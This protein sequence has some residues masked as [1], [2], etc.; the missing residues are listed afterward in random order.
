MDLFFDGVGVK[1]A[2]LN[3]LIEDFLQANPEAPE[4]QEEL[5][6]AF[7]KWLNLPKN[8][9]SNSSVRKTS[10][11]LRNGRRPL[12]PRRSVFQKKP[13]FTVLNAPSP[14]VHT[15]L[16]LYFQKAIKGILQLPSIDRL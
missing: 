9:F 2:Y 15:V 12:P 4:N 14:E 11:R 8:D 7:S 5:R 10:S 16:N 13:S 6:E 1:K 3:S